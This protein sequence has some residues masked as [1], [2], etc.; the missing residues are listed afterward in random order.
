MDSLLELSV[1]AEG[2]APG[3]AAVSG[4]ELA[5]ALLHAKPQEHDPSAAAADA[6]GVQALGSERDEGE[7]LE[8]AGN[9]LTAEF[10]TLIDREMESLSTQPPLF[11]SVLPPV[12]QD[13]VP[14]QALPE[15]LQ[16]SVGQDLRPGLG[17]QV[18]AEGGGHEFQN[19]LPAERVELLR[20]PPQPSRATVGF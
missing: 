3:P 12:P 14:S 10:D 15:L 4:F 7:D 5:A 2:S 13:A 9:R 18:Q 8:V 20:G 6:N 11:D 19:P 16:S 17:Q 1:A